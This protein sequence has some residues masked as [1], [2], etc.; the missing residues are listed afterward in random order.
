MQK[1][2][3]F[4]TK[5]VILLRIIALVLVAVMALGVISCK[6]NNSDG[7]EATAEKSFVFEVTFASGETKTYSYTSSCETVGEALFDEGI[8]EGENGDYGLYVKTV[9]GVTLDYATDGMYWAFYVNGAYAS[10]GVDTTPL[11]DGETYAFRAEK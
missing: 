7:Q 1:K 3:S 10:S 11:K 6:A 9:D 8:I 2:L 5:S 4:S